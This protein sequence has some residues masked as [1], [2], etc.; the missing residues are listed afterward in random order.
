MSPCILIM[1]SSSNNHGQDDEAFLKLLSS[2]RELLQRINRE[3]AMNLD[4]QQQH[5]QQQQHVHQQYHP[6]HH[7]HQFQQ[8]YRFQTNDAR[9]HISHKRPR[10]PSPSIIGPSDP[11]SLMNTLAP[12]DSNEFQTSQRVIAENR[13]GAGLFSGMSSFL[14]SQHGDE[15]KYQGFPDPKNDETKCHDKVDLGC[16]FLSAEEDPRHTGG[17]SSPIP[18]S[19]RLSLLSTIGSGDDSFAGDFANSVEAT[20]T[21][22]TTAPPKVPPAIR[23]YPSIPTETVH[24]QLSRFVTSMENSAKSQQVIHDWDRT[25]G[26]KRSH[27]K[28]MRLTMRSRKKLRQLLKKDVNHLAKSNRATT[29]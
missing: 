29:S 25:M 10:R 15:E 6:Y 22:P 3:K 19:R 28:T 12:A 1:S 2:Q 27:S 7:Q 14:R 9:Q 23:I 11:M 18:L 17:A 4:Q 13:F 24:G 5:A 16:S 21:R 20:S 26:L 8:Q